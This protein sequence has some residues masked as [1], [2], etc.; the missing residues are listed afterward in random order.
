MDTNNKKPLFF[1]TIINKVDNKGRVSFPAEYRMLAKKFE[2]DLVIFR[3]FTRKCIEGCSED[4]M[5]NLAAD[6]LNSHDFFSEEQDELTDL[7]FGDSKR[8]SFD[9]TGRTVI[10]EKFL[11]HAGITEQAVFVGKGNKFQIWNLSDFECEQKRIRENIKNRK[12]FV[13]HQEKAGDNE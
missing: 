5:Q 2:T 1:D 3:S 9:S 4:M 6:I 13:K 8:V 7:V 11:E 10:P 12:N